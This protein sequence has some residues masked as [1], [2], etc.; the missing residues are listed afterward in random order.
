MIYVVFS[1]LFL[2]VINISI[3][4]HLVIRTCVSL[5]FGFLQGIFSGLNFC[6]QGYRRLAQAGLSLSFLTISNFLKWASFQTLIFHFSDN[7][8]TKNFRTKNI[9][10]LIWTSFKNHLSFFVYH[11]FLKRTTD[12]KSCT[13]NYFETHW[14]FISYALC[15][16]YI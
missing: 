16:A 1:Y 6:F 13:S 11:N 7:F 4:S 2:T 8:P 5:L 10:L 14:N 12:V 9:T 3:T 15:D